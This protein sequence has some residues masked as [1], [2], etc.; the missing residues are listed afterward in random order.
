MLVIEIK[1]P[2]DVLPRRYLVN[3]S[4]LTRFLLLALLLNAVHFLEIETVHGRSCG[5]FVDKDP[6]LIGRQRAL[7]ALPRENQRP[8]GFFRQVMA[9]DT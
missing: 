6:A 8:D 7:L 1:D 9:H 3:E 4:L 5:R 2:H